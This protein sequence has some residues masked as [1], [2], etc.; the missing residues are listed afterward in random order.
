MGNGTSTTI[1]SENEVAGL[2]TRSRNAHSIRGSVFNS[3]KKRQLHLQLCSV[4]RHT[5]R[6]DSIYAFWKGD[7]WTQTR[8]FHEWPI[9][10]PLSDDGFK[11]ASEE[12]GPRLRQFSVENNSPILVVVTSPYFRCVQTAVGVCKALGSKGRIIIDRELGEVFGPSVLGNLK[13]ARPIR[14]ME[15]IL[16]FC[17]MHEVRCL[18]RAVGVWPTWPEDLTS[19]RRRY[20]HRYLTYL[21][22]STLTRRNFVLVTHGDGVGAALAIM[23]S[24][25]GKRLKRVDFG[26]M[27]LC[28]RRISGS[29]ST[30]SA[31]KSASSTRCAKSVSEIMTPVLPFD[32]C[33][34]NDGFSS[35]CDESANPIGRRA[36]S[37]SSMS[38]MSSFGSADGC[39]WDGLTSANCPPPIASDGWVVRTYDVVVQERADPKPGS[40]K[41]RIA[42]LIKGS[43]L[44]AQQVG[45]LLGALG[46]SPLGGL[47]TE[48]CL[49]MPANYT[50]AALTA[51]SMSTC[52]F[53]SST[54][55][56]SFGSE[57]D[58]ENH[59]VSIARCLTD[60]SGTDYGVQNQDWKAFF[61]NRKNR[62]FAFNRL[63]HKMCD[64]DLPRAL[65]RSVTQLADVDE[66]WMRNE[67]SPVDCPSRSLWRSET[68][69]GNCVHEFKQAPFQQLVPSRE[70]PLPSDSP[71]ESRLKSQ[72]LRHTTR[73]DSSPATFH[74][75]ERSQNAFNIPEL[76]RSQAEEHT[77]VVE[78]GTGDCK[79]QTENLEI[80]SAGCGSALFQRR[81]PMTFTLPPLVVHGIHSAKNNSSRPCALPQSAGQGILKTG[82]QPSGIVLN[83]GAAHLSSSDKSRQQVPPITCEINKLSPPCD[84]N[85]ALPGQILQSAT[86]DNLC[87]KKSSLM[88]R[89]LSKNLTCI[90]TSHPDASCTSSLDDTKDRHGHACLNNSADHAPPLTDANGIQDGKAINFFI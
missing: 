40:V 69:P 86:T 28:S 70:D 18:P 6:A 72:D 9:D 59:G 78:T 49:Q 25:T 5:E 81:C 10:P 54:F 13:P 30:P 75:K 52:M 1:V 11:T 47:E 31:S 45:D 43:A 23:P 32:P 15:E 88:Q 35:D 62:Q 41:N 36:S 12:I 57:L 87:I 16:Q 53:G 64:N 60:S 26:G 29:T 7:R 80:P 19:A 3:W 58:I 55:G 4:V 65:T 77:A 73:T 48:D 51:V 20:A 85:P 76:C 17:E 22:R 61:K 84:A 37:H 68:E 27:F 89:R 90:S 71:S 44:S 66:L 42:N 74:I 14:P 82:S 39:G 34:T 50:S 8:D 56:T 83:C 67:D 38:S 33:R 2:P 46:D 24:H 63:R 79:F 21:R